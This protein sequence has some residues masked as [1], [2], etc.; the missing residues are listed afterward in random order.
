MI[1]ARVQLG[2]IDSRTGTER[3]INLDG[4]K[5]RKVTGFKLVKPRLQVE[6]LAAIVKGFQEEAIWWV[7]RL[8]SLPR[9]MI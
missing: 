7:E 1:V 8:R 5:F 4:N 2:L 3:A 9:V 6:D